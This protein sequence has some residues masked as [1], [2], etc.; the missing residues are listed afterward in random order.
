[1]NALFMSGYTD[2][3][4]VRHGVL[5]ATSA[6]LAKPITVASLTTR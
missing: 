1:M 5:L 2:S 3:S 4:I 6:F